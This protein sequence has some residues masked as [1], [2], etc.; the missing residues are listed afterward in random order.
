MVERKITDK[1]NWPEEYDPDLER[2]IE[3]NS[4]YVKIERPKRIAKNKPTRRLTTLKPK[5]PEIALFFQTLEEP[6]FMEMD[7]LGRAGD[8][9]HYKKVEVFCPIS[10]SPLLVYLKHIKSGEK[11]VVVLAN[12]K[13][14]TYEQYVILPGVVHT[15]VNPSV[16]PVPYLVLSNVK[17]KEAIGS[18]D[19]IDHRLDLL[20]FPKPQI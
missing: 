10:E 8:H 17:E 1:T 7:G 11:T 16:K 12:N 20:S 9:V 15:I 13:I 2:I 19:V 5:S 3:S 4:L 18:G 14:D 6:Y